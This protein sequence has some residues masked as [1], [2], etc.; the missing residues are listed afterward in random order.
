[1]QTEI[2]QHRIDWWYEDESIVE[3]PES[4][5]EHIQ[6]SIIDGCSSGQLVYENEI[7][8]TTG[9]WKIVRT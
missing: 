9:W 4:E 2:L 3:L 6:Q 5:E 1:M 8:E 7:I